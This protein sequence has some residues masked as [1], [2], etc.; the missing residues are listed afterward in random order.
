MDQLQRLLDQAIGGEYVLPDGRAFW[1]DAV[2]VRA[3]LGRALPALEEWVLDDRSSTQA[4]TNQ[5]LSTEAARLDA[6]NRHLAEENARLK[7]EAS[8]APDRVLEAVRQGERDRCRQ[9]FLAFAFDYFGWK[10]KDSG[11]EEVRNML[12]DIDSGTKV[13]ERFVFLE[14]DVLNHGLPSIAKEPHEESTSPSTTSSST[15]TG[16]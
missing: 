14:K 6:D 15:D 9:L 11:A 3:I 16:T 8:F 1:L 2:T 7:A 12:E 4:R 5:R 10:L 13:H